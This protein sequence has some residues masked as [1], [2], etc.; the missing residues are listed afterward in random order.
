MQ[1][2]NKKEKNKEKEVDIM[3]KIN[4][5]KLGEIRKNAG[6][7]QRELAKQLGVSPSAISHY[8]KGDTNPSDETLEKICVLLKITKDDV[9]IKNLGYSF[10]DQISKT[11]NNARNRKGFVHYLNPEETEEWIT[12]KRK[13]SDEEEKT[14]IKNALRNSFGIGNKKYVLIDPVLIHVPNWQRTTDMAKTEEIAVNFDEDKF[15][16]IKVYINEER[17]NVADG[18]HRLVS[19]IKRN[20]NKND[21][22]KILAEV[23]SCNEYEAI[24]TFL[25]QQ[26]GR[27][28]MTVSDTYRAAIKANITDYLTFKEIFESYNIQITAEMETL[29]NPVGI[30]KPSAGALRL[31]NRNKTELKIALDLINDLHW[32][33]STEKNAYTLRTIRTLIKLCAT[34]G[35]TKTEQKLLNRCKGATYYESKV[36]PVKSNAELYDLLAE[37]IN[38]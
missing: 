22:V 2:K 35:T 8:E 36:F 18:A 12:S 31:A 32:N 38:K 5:K 37:E 15:D 7:S 34:F 23:L 24:N 3:C 1:N 4:G 9:E 26:S 25:G 21:K 30:I 17:F 14:E 33:G 10:L 19:V 6:M 16:P 20:I 28:P 13:L 27:K 11:A 29:S